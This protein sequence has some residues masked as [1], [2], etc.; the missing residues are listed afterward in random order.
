MAAEAGLRVRNPPVA[1][2]VSGS[3]ID[4]LLTYS[5]VPVAVHVLAGFTADSDHTMVVGKLPLELR[6]GY[7]ALI[8]RVVWASTGEWGNVGFLPRH[9]SV[10]DGIQ[11]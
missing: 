1:T 6:L 3:A 4:L 5:R 10:L 7:D 2:R 9:A 8:G 11:R